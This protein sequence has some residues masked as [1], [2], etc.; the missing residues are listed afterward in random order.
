M[1]STKCTSNITV[2]N[3]QH[4]LK[5]SARIALAICQEPLHYITK[6]DTSYFCTKTTS[7]HSYPVCSVCHSG[8]QKPEATGWMK[9][10]ELLSREEP[11]ITSSL[12]LHSQNKHPSL[13]QVCAQAL[14][15]AS[16]LPPSATSDSATTESISPKI[17]RTSYWSTLCF[18]NRY[19]WSPPWN[20]GDG[21]KLN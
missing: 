6:G 2:K 13:A 16:Q 5:T 9:Q 3:L 20:T 1:F 21:Y 7:C 4:I 15:H 19:K 18:L 12:P 11:A 17:K 10:K 14:L 8:R